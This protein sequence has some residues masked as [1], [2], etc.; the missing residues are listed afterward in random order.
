MPEAQSCLGSFYLT[1]EGATKNYQKAYY[2]LSLASKN[3]QTDNDQEIKEAK[4]KVTLLQF[5]YINLLLL[6]KT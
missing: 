3:G 1:G 6:L 5:L 4:T 2:W